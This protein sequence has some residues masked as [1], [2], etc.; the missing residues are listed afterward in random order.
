MQVAN[1]MDDES[2]LKVMKGALIA[3]SSFT[4]ALLFF[5]AFGIGIDKALLA[6]FVTWAVPVAINAYHQY[7]RGSDKPFPEDAP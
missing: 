6:S 3:L 5:V 7:T 1:Q 2:K 4:V